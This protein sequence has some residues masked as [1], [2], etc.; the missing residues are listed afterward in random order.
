M[1]KGCLDRPLR[2]SER[3]IEKPLQAVYLALAAR[4][5]KRPPWMRFEVY[6]RYVRAMRALSPLAHNPTNAHAVYSNLPIKV[7]S[8][9]HAQSEPQNEY[10]IN[11]T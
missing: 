9:L 10:K 11:P 3:P 4:D 8:S 2:A 1:H 7:L 5:L 6:I